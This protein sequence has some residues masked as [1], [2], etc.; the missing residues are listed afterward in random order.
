V[1]QLGF[2]SDSAPV[3]TKL[4]GKPFWM[5]DL[6]LTKEVDGYAATFAR[7]ASPDEIIIEVN[8]E[9]RTVT[10]DFWQDLPLYQSREHRSDLA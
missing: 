4:S 8:G 9:Y 5:S 1:N 7:F 10:R 3:A 6:F 2:A